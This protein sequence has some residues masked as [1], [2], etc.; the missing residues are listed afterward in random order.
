MGRQEEVNTLENSIEKEKL[1]IE[2]LKRYLDLKE[3]E[4]RDK[5]NKL[6]INNDEDSKD[7]SIEEEKTKYGEGV[8]EDDL[9]ENNF[10]SN[11]TTTNNINKFG[12]V[13]YLLVSYISGIITHIFTKRRI[14]G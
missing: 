11:E 7:L 10:E 2:S 9:L 6:L 4:L 14:H 13:F 5:E 1:E 3:K 12:N 8:L